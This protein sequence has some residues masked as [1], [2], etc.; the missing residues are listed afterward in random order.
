MR[1]I[2]RKESKD[3]RRPI[4]TGA[5]RSTT[6]TLKSKQNERPSSRMG[7]QQLEPIGSALDE[8]ERISA[9]FS[10]DEKSDRNRIKFVEK[11]NL[12]TASSLDVGDKLQEKNQ[13]A[14]KIM[15]RLHQKNKELEAEIVKLVHP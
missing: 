10:K 7:V 5:S 1:P 14:E 6:P 8:L 2:Q 11:N 4:S 3:K 12:S 9:S 13:M 15:K